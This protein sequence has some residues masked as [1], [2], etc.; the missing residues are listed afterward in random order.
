MSS[1]YKK[2][3]T[4]GFFSLTCHECHYTTI[5]HLQNINS[6]K[7]GVAE[8]RDERVM[9]LPQLPSI[10]IGRNLTV[11]PSHTTWHTGPYQGGSVS[12]NVWLSTQSRETD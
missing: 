1:V 10:G 7:N 5:R 4:K 9:V 12:L 8:P 2:S 6:A 3:L 11:P